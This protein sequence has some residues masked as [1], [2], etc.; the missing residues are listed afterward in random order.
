MMRK[1]LAAGAVFLLLGLLLAAAGGWYLQQFLERPNPTAI[2]FTVGKGWSLNRVARELESRGVI[3]SADMFRLVG[4]FWGKGHI[5]A[6]E[7]RLEAGVKPQQVLEHLRRGQVVQHRIVIPEG[8]SNRDIIFLMSQRQWPDIGKVIA[9]PATRKKLGVEAVSLEGWLFPDTYFYN[10]DESAMQIVTRMV[11]RTQQV[12]QEEWAGRP[13]EIEARLKSPY[14][15]LIFASIIEKETG[16]PQE[17]PL[18]SGVFHNRLKINMR[19]QSDPTVIYG[20]P[21]YDG[22]IKR[23]HL[24]TPTPYNTYTEHGLT[25][26][27][28]ANPGREAIHAALHPATTEAFYFVAKGDGSKSHRFSK[29]LKEHERNVKRYLRA[30][31]KR[32]H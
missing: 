32:R 15:A 3:S 19:L 12:L 20:I 17:R 8:F 4:R 18:I 13:K 16:Q 22:D 9:D 27:P 25:P 5:R 2:G 11:K 23:K 1:L 21:D 26:T 6:G 31:R 28:I 29:T 30:L 24:T 14:D 7:Y 10:K